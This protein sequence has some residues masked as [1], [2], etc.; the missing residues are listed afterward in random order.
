MDFQKIFAFL[1]PFRTGKPKPLLRHNFDQKL[2]RRVRPAILPSPQQ[3]KYVF[4][5][6]TRAEKNIIK[7]AFFVTT[8]TLAVWIVFFTFT[9][10]STAPKSGGDYTEGVVGQPKL[11]NPLYSPLNETDADL[12]SLLYSG[13]FRHNKD[14][15]LVPD[16]AAGYSISDDKK[17][18]TVNL[19]QDV[20]WS[21]G[22]PFTADDI[23]YTFETIQNPETGSPLL[24]A[25]QGVK[26]ERLDDYSVRFV[27]REK[28]AP[29]LDS[30]TVGILPE[31]VWS[32]I[33]PSNI[34]LAKNNL[35]P[36]G[37]GPWI[38]EKLVKDDLGNIQLYV[39]ERNNN[40]YQTLPHL[41]TV[42]LKFY[43]DYAQAV[44]A[45][46]AQSISALSFIPR[47]LKEKISKKLFNVFELQFPQ[48]T[49]LFFNP[50]QQ[51]ALKNQDVREALAMA[52][53]KKV[54]LDEA[55]D[56]EGTVIDAPILPGG[57][58][59]NPNIKKIEHNLAEANRLLDKTYSRIPPEEYFKIRKEAALKAR[60]PIIEMTRKNPSS[61]PEMVS[62][63]ALNMEKEAEEI[64]RGEMSADQ[65]FYRVDKNKNIFQLVITTADTDEYARTAES[66]AKFWRAAGIQTSIQKVSSRQIPK[67]TLKERNYQILLYGEIL[68]G[69]PDLYPFWHSSQTEY[70]GLNLSTFID[71]S[72]DKLLEDARS[73]LDNKERDELYKKFQ[74]TLSKNLSAIF[75]YSPT[76]TFLA[77]KEIKGIDLGRIYTSSNRY[78]GLSDWYIKTKWVI[79]P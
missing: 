38:F 54:I 8:A 27:L 5:F 11:I 31:H 17:A 46:R 73:T 47:N 74:D 34:R 35:Q 64:A 37:T 56:G 21:D 66:V 53:D 10:L 77:A 41:K 61:T 25:F 72:S 42:T 20:A 16:L 2:V 71:R 55:V 78:S 3:V 59:Y 30:L 14:M 36:I 70:P 18:Y 51:A 48:Y 39:L 69:D 44:D 50:N 9:H 4:R 7:A 67:E 40:Y 15:K 28:Y 68:G 79:K 57:I 75:L 19:R 62:S 49:A 52:L 23:I 1:K 60:L 13:L 58:G 24:S 6:L 26:V 32:N 29:F 76:Y 63:T 12:V 45:L 65:T 22:E 43:N 33:A